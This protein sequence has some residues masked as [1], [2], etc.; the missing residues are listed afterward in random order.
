MQLTDQ[1]RERLKVLSSSDDGAFLREILDRYILELKDDAIFG[2]LPKDAAKAAIL[3][4][5][6]LKNKMSVLSGGKAAP[7]KNMFT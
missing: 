5:E 1:Q 3:K 4:L 6:E 2:E 7:S